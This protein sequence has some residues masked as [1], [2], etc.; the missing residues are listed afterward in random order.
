MSICSYAQYTCTFPKDTE[1]RKGV[2]PSTLKVN[3][4]DEYEVCAD[5]EGY[6]SD[7]FLD[8]LVDLFDRPLDKVPGLYLDAYYQCYDDEGWQCMLEIKDGKVTCQETEIVWKPV[9]LDETDI[10]IG[11]PLLK[12]ARAAWDRLTDVPVDDDGKIL[13]RYA[14]PYWNYYPAG[15]ERE[16][17]WHEIERI[18][19]VSVAYLMGLCKNP[20]GTD[21]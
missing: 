10:D 4:N 7:N 14:G 5:T 11:Q 20:D 1:F 8:N 18:C 12:Q 2:D 19:H 16:Y 15:T 21:E 13:E 3:D 6:G 17:I 9:T